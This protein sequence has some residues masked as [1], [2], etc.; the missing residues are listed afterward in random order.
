MATRRRKTAIAPETSSRGYESSAQ[1]AAE[2]EA[3]QGAFHHIFDYVPFKPVAAVFAAAILATIIITA[4]ETYY[5]HLESRFK[6]ALEEKNKAEGEFK[7][8][9]VEKSNAKI[10]KYADALHA[11]YRNSPKHSELVNIYYYHYACRSLIEMG[12][13]DEALKRWDAL[14]GNVNK[15]AIMSWA[16]KCEPE[17]RGII[18]WK[19]NKTQEAVKYFQ[20]ALKLNPSFLDAN[21]YLGKY[22]FGEKKYLEAAFYLRNCLHSKVHEPEARKIIQQIMAKI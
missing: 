13:E 9:V 2:A 20:N 11:T 14:K 19:K 6:K 21:F 7:Q 8:A 15:E 5:H 18:A 3:A 17:I 12:K 4:P 22:L 16:Y 1:M 10:V